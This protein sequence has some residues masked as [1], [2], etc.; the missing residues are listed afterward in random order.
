M[1]VWASEIAGPT[2]PGHLARPRSAP[3]S[4]R[5]RWVLPATVAA[6]DGAAALLATLGAVW[7][8]YRQPIALDVGPA[9][10]DAGA[11]ALGLAVAWVAVLAA[12]GAYR[13]GVV[14]AGVDD[15]RRVLRAGLSLLGAL[16]IGH[17]V[18]FTDLSGR[19]I[20]LSVALVVAATLAVRFV[21]HQVLARTRARHR[22][23][24]RAVL[25]GSTAE[26]GALARCLHAGVGPGV[27]VVGTCLTD[28]DGNGRHGSDGHAGANGNRHPGATGNGG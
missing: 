12:H 4:T 21:A 2:R 9:K 8:R 14:G 7:L 1:T 23:V 28:G 16:A 15:M 10:L 26:T 25:Y 19:L 22:W 13:R 27:Q 5:W 11:A 24:R 20:L 6:A 18:V 3:A 17:L